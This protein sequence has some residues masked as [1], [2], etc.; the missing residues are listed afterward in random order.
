MGFWFNLIIKLHAKK[1]KRGK[2]ERENLAFDLLGF[3]FY[4]EL[5]I[6]K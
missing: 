1:R 3:S 4:P 6:K 5:K 2:E